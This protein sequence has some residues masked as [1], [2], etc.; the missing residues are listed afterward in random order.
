MESTRTDMIENHHN[1]SCVL[2]RCGILSAVVHELAVGLGNK[3]GIGVKMS[4]KGTAD[5]IIHHHIIS[6]EAVRKSEVYKSCSEILNPKSAM[7][8]T[9]FVYHYLQSSQFT[10][11][12]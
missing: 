2:F 10:I 11:H 7:N 6:H 8:S 3:M 1:V 12:N 9:V 5:A 4:N